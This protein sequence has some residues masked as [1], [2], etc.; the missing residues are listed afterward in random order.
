MKNIQFSNHDQRLIHFILYLNTEID[1]CTWS[2]DDPTLNFQQYIYGKPINR[3]VYC[4]LVDILKLYVYVIE[5][6]MS[7]PY[8]FNRDLVDI[9]LNKIKYL[10]GIPQLLGSTDLIIALIKSVKRLPIH[11]S[12]ENQLNNHFNRIML[13]FYKDNVPDDMK[14]LDYESEQK[15]LMLYN[16]FR[17]KSILKILIELIKFQKNPNMYIIC[18]VYELKSLNSSKSPTDIGSKM[19][20]HFLSVIMQKCI[21][22]CNFSINTWLSWYEIEVIEDDTNLQALIGHMCFD[23]CTLIDNGSINEDILKQFRPILNN[24][25]IEKIDLTNVDT[26]NIDGMI[27]CVENCSKLHL[28]NWIKKMIENLDVFTYSRAI[29]TLDNFI[30]SIDCNCFKRLIDRFIIYHKNGGILLESLGKVIHKGIMHMDLDDKINILKHIMTK[31]PDNMFYLTN[32]FDNKLK[33][34]AYN[35]NEESAD[36]NVSHIK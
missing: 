25:A 34:V 32:E 7:T 36:Q 28:N 4:K 12:L 33:Y 9:I 22:M 18:P 17:V 6:V 29:Q 3:N 13:V 8:C 20:N 10:N 2:K 30:E 27:D 1:D 16:G 11:S 19:F 35:E 23:L 24:M 21:N 31:Y 15:L 26:N 14:R 5:M